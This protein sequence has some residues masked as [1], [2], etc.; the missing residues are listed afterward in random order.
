MASG[1]GLISNNSPSTVG[2][3]VSKGLY[4]WR[5]LGNAVGTLREVG[6]FGLIARL[7]TGTSERV[8]TAR[9]AIAGLDV[10]V[11]VIGRLVEGDGVR[12]LDEHGRDVQPPRTGWDHFQ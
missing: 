11:T 3:A 12:L 10:P 4:P 9:R 2:V 8:E 1:G 6:E 5:I 7:F